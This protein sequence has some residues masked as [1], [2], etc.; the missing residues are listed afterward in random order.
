MY[1]Q[2][3]YVSYW[4][5]TGERLKKCKTKNE[6]ILARHMFITYTPCP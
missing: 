4:D 5:K 3:N 1:G 2:K 6:M